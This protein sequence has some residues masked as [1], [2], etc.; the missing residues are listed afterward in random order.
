MGGACA[1]QRYAERTSTSEVEHDADIFSDSDAETLVMGP[2][3]HNDDID[4]TGDDN[5][6]TYQGED[7]GDTG[8]GA[9]PDD[10]KKDRKVSQA[11]AKFMAI[12]LVSDALAKLCAPRKVLLPPAMLRVHYSQ[13]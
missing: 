2:P 13:V 4:M 1:K 3:N 6:D 10:D 7:K 12:S 8:Q 5:G 9:G 11:Q